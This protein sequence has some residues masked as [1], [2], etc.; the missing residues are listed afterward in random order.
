MTDVRLLSPPEWGN[1][2]PARRDS[3]EDR[4]GRGPTAKPPGHV[5]SHEQRKAAEEED[6]LYS[7]PERKVRRIGRAL[8]DDLNR[9][10]R[11]WMTA[12]MTIPTT[13]LMSLCKS[14][15]VLKSL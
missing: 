5:L 3:R 10:D 6:K 12:R 9:S 7:L 8:A 13:I 4:G 11:A 14:K 15:W 2:S 1:T